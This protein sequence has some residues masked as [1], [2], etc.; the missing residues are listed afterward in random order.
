MSNI[1]ISHAQWPTDGAISLANTDNT[2]T[3]RHHSEESAICVC[4]R[5][6]RDGFG[7]DGIEFPVRTWV[8]KETP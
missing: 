6:V 5:L 1:W 3:D 4:N 2:S 7:G 8:T